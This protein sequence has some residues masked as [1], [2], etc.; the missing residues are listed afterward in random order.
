MFDSL[1][2]LAALPGDTRVCCAHEY[3]EDNLRFAWMVEPD[4]DAL[5]ARIRRDWALRAEGRCTVPSTIEDERATNPFLRPGSE[6]LRAQL[7]ERMP[8]ADLSTH[9]AVFA[10]TRR[11]KDR[12]DHRQR[13]DVVLPL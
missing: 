4:N 1:L 6:S 12:K 2:R 5:A 3:T 9:D 10:A 8:D 7:R 13:D 11:L